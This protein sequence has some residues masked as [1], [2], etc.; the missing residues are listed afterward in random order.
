MRT[1]CEKGCLKNPSVAER[2]IERLL[3]RNARAAGLFDSL[4]AT[5][6]LSSPGQ[7]KKIDKT[8]QSCPKV[9]ICF[10]QIQLKNIAKLIC[11]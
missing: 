1:A 11:I 2:R 3:Q 7:E 8:G 10:D 9:V 5:V 6:N 4:I